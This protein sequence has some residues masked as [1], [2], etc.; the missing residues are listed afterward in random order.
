V[1]NKYLLKK[2]EDEWITQH[3]NEKLEEE[4]IKTHVQNSQ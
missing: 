1:I 3:P 4:V 2:Q